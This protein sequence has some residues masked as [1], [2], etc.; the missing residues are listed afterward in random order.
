MRSVAVLLLLLAAAQP[1]GAFETNG[2]HWDEMPVEYWINPTECPTLADGSSVIDLVAAATQAWADVACADIAFV[3]MG[4]TDLT[5]DADDQNTIFCISDPAAWQFGVGAAG[6]TL[7]IPHEE[8][9]TAEVDLALNAA[10]LEW[11]AGGGDALEQG[12]MDPQSMI[13]HELG[14]WLGLAHT[15]DPYGTMYYGLLPNG[16]QA[17][18]SGDDKAGVC[19]LYPSGVDDCATD[20]DCPGDHFCADIQG[21]RVCDELHD[22]AGAECD[23]GHIDCEQ[24]CWVSLYECQHICYFTDPLQGTA[25]YCAPVCDP[26][27]GV[28]CPEGYDCTAIAQLSG[29]ICIKGFT[30]IWPTADDPPAAVERVAEVVEEPA[31]DLVAEELPGGEDPAG[32][33]SDTAP[34]PDTTPEAPAGGGESGGCAAGPVSTPTLAPL[35]LL[36]AIAIL[37]RRPCGRG[38]CA[39]NRPGDGPPAA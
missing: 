1:A 35:L 36:M 28:G 2:R 27:A 10:D 12:I 5:W 25:G 9:Y 15:P 32:P 13:T 14:H 3:F 18:L 33:V 38:V 23:K 17:T 29:H 21:I 6:A 20:G 22:P 37:R 7:W 4:T 30:P 11:R 24:M 39:P 26:D 19:S 31:A 34:S 8:S 16:L